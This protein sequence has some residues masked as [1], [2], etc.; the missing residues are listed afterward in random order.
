MS[1]TTAASD[2]RTMLSDNAKD[3]HCYRKKVL[4][5]A[6][7]TNTRFKTMEFRRIQNFKQTDNLQ[8]DFAAPPLG[9]WKNGVLLTPADFADDYPPLG[10]FTLTTAPENTDTLEASYFAQW[11][12]DEE[13]IQFLRISC[14]WLALG[15]DYTTA[16]GPGLRPAALKY[17]AAEAYQKLASRWSQMLSEQFL[18]QDAQEKGRFQIVDAWM[19]AADQNRKEAY[20]SRDDFYSRSGQ[21]NV[22]Y[23]S[24]IQGSVPNPVP[25][26]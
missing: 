24:S 17:A 26:R 1:W 3:K 9:V 7:G 11:F 6:N 14:N 13:I 22:P 23:A 10:D 18:M 20:K 12:N 16:V 21:Q 2:L 4:G 15:D 25:Q 19:K 8:P 5:D